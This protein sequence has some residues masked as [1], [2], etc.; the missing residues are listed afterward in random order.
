MCVSVFG[1]QLLQVAAVGNVFAATCFLEG[2]AVEDITTAEL[3]VR[4]PNYDVLI[5]I[6]AE[7]SSTT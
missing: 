4:D 7:K 2:I 5:T 3:D 1:E 6:H